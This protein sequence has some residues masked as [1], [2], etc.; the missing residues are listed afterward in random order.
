M[1]KFALL[2]CIFS[3][4]LTVAAGCGQEKRCLM[5]GSV[6]SDGE[7]VPTGI[8]NFVP[9]NPDPAKG[10]VGASVDI[11]DGVYAMDKKSKA[12]LLPGKYKVS[13]VASY[14]RDK[15][16]KEVVSID[17]VKDGLVDPNSIEHVD[18]VPP[19]YGSESEQFVEVGSASAMTYDINMVSE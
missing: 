11:I 7:P 19:K 13:V 16:T 4:V 17:D 8:V 2:C 1:K 18:V 6:T 12:G 5:S 9:E 10:T 15:K 3:L 14:S